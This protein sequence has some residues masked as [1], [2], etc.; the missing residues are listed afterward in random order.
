MILGLATAMPLAYVVVFVL[1][2]MPHL[3]AVGSPGGV[4]ESNFFRMFGVA[5]FLHIT[6]FC[7]TAVLLAFYGIF[8]Y[9][10]ATVPVS[11]R[12]MW[13]VVLLLGNILAMPV[14]WY[15]CVW[16]SLTLENG[17]EPQTKTR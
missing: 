4:G 6:V 12:R 16:R 17:S 8:I 9:R 13:T 2:I 7:L 11:Q 1:Y 3:T 10:G 15:S 14:I 5:W